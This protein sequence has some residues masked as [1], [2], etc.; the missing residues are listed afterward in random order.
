MEALPRE[1]VRVLR[2]FEDVFSERVWDWVQVLV[3]GAI[4]T[5]GQ[6]TVAAVLRVMGL[7]DERQY[8]N[9]HRVLNRARWSS[10]E[11]SRRLLVL[12]V[13]VFVPADA[14]VLVGVDE[15]IER[16]RGAKIAA[17]G[18]YRDPVRSSKRHFVKASGLRWLSVMLLAPIP[19][20]K[21]I[22]ALP[23]LTALAPSERY[24]RER[25]VR[26]KRLT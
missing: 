4:L 1:I 5:P 17:K 26:H 10:R 20:A 12:V 11:L 16:R 3:V 22:W 24:A 25:G 2:V 18:I 13:Q 6:R 14:P 15:T 19:W 8:Q 9:Y 7:S 23:V 21:R